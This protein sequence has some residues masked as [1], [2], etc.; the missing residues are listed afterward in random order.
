V[1]RVCENCAFPDEDLALVRR[2][3]VTPESW[4]RQ[5]AAEVVDETELWCVSCRS[6]YPHESADQEQEDA[7]AD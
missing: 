6:Q 2:V 4:D 5:A 7:E 1:D 3:Y